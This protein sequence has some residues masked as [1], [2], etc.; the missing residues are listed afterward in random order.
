MATAS[1][2]A[3]QSAPGNVHASARSISGYHHTL[4]VWKSKEHMLDF[5]H[6]GIHA[7]AIRLFPKI[8]KGKTVGFYCHDVPGWDMALERWTKDGIGYSTGSNG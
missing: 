6:T 4:S 3:A 2:V 8:A 7:T 5:V 1:M